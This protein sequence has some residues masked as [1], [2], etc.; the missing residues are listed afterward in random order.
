MTKLVA[1]RNGDKHDPLEVAESLDELGDGSN[2]AIGEQLHEAADV[3]RA[4]ATANDRCPLCAGM[5]ILPNFMDAPGGP[6]CACGRPSIHESGACTFDHNAIPC[7]RCGDIP[8]R[9]CLGK[10]TV[11]VWG[12]SPG[13][14]RYFIDTMTCDRCKGTGKESAHAA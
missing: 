4:L 8:C 14:V 6:R 11:E 1:D 7:P 10:R 2:A 12:T 5:R 13:G 9:D 3:M